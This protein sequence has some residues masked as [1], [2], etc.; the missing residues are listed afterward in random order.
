MVAEPA[1]ATR[2]NPANPSFGGRVAAVA[3]H[4]G[5]PLMPWQ[6]TVADVVTE[7][8]PTKPGAWRYPLVVISVPR[9]AGKTALLRALLV[10]RMLCYRKHEILMTAQTGKD[11]RKRWKQITK[12]LDSKK[13]KNYF[14]TYE[15]RG[16]EELE[17][18]PTGSFIAPFAP[19]PKSIHGDSLHCVAIDEAWAF[20]AESGHDLETAI[21]PTQLTVKDSQL[22]VVSTKGTTESAYLNQLIAR[23]RIAVEDPAAQVAY[24]EWSADPQLAGEDPYSDATLSFHPAIGHTQTAEKMRAL[25]SGDLAAWKRSILNLDAEVSEQ[26]GPVNLAIWD[27][28]AAVEHP[29]PPA[30]SQVSV[31]FDIARDGS[32]ATVAA[33]WL[34]D[35]GATVARILR[36]GPMGE[37]LAG[38]LAQARE[39]GYAGIFADDSGP[40]RTMTADLAETTAITSLSP[41]EYASACQLFIDRVRSGELTHDGTADVRT[42]LKA[43]AV[44]PMGGA[45]AFDPNKSNGPIDMVRA[46][47]VAVYE[48]NQHRPQALQL[49]VGGKQ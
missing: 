47:A 9:Q 5:T 18:L 16:G 15:S 38:L 11:A 24:F 21:M 39:A 42:Q 3:A 40:A 29:A 49:F 44:R 41:R 23:G 48:A 25:A 20:D 34:D 45:V 33:A 43:T 6:R 13:K 17:Y 46:L 7:L 35:E 32:A 27:S 2:R 8:D 1:Y 12:A 37:W 4:L 10:D 30:P 28:L 14:R 31:A 22:I 36:S 19:T 26:S